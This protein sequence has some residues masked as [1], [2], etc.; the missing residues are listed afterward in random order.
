MILNRYARCQV[1][2]ITTL[3]L[4]ALIGAA[5][6]GADIGLR[7]YNWLQ[8]QKAADAAVIAGANYLPS[9]TA[10][11]IATA[12][13]YAFQNGVARSEILS[14]D[15]APNGM[16]ITML[17]SRTVPYFFT[18]VLGLTNAPVKAAA[19]AGLQPNT[20]SARGLLPIGLPCNSGGN[21]KYTPGTEYQLKQGQT[22]PGNWGALA[23]GGSGAATYRTNLEIGFTGSIPQN[24]TTEPG[25]LVGP[26]Q[27]AINDRLTLAQTTDPNGSWKI[28]TPYDPRLVVVPMV[29]FTTAKGKSSLPI[30]SYALMWIDS[31]TG[32]NATTNAYF[33]STIPASQITS[34]TGNCGMLNP[35]LEQ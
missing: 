19:T 2:V 7:Y 12:N 5:G 20:E 23:L 16:S 13:S 22:G 1:A 33:L 29:D 9:D 30:V 10:D 25:D 4:T 21:C 3:I 28:P 34:S 31:V 11:A 14:T 15:V 8:L 6:L 32:N 18:R 26:T 24:V 27:Q 17:V 35:I